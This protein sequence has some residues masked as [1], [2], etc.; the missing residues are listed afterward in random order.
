V[1]LPSQLWSGM[2]ISTIHAP[3]VLHGQ[4]TAQRVGV[5]AQHMGM[6]GHFLGVHWGWWVF[7]VFVVVSFGVLILRAMDGGRDDS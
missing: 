6:P 4:S 7:S 5:P 3:L 2:P 1:T